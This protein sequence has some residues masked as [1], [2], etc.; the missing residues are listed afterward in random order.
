MDE[1]KEMFGAEIRERFPDLADEVV[2]EFVA[3]SIE[4]DEL[5]CK[6]LILD[7]CIFFLQPTS[8]VAYKVLLLS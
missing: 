1:K 6:S 3:L 4:N 2:D 7:R 8:V 5:T